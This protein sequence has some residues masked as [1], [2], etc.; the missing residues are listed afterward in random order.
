MIEKELRKVRWELELN[1]LE[2]ALLKHKAMT[3]E[4]FEAQNDQVQREN[5]MRQQ[6]NT[7]LMARSMGGGMYGGYGSQHRAR[8][9]SAPFGLF[10][11]MKI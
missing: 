10:G 11:V 5:I 4:E 8:E 2:Q 6:Q 1:R 3:C 9:E 7:A